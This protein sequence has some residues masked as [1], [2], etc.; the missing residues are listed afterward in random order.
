MFRIIKA[1]QV[2][3]GAGT[4]LGAQ[5]SYVSETAKP[6][7]IMR[8]ADRLVAAFGPEMQLAGETALEVEVHWA[9]DSPAPPKLKYARQAGA[10]T[11]TGELNAVA[12]GEGVMPADPLFAFDA[13][14]LSAAAAAALSWLE[15]MDNDAI[16]AAVRGMNEEFRG[17]VR[18]APARWVNVLRERAALGVPKHR[19]ELYR[20]QTPNRD[21]VA[22]P[23]DTALIEYESDGVRGS[24][25]LERIVMVRPSAEA[26]WRT[27]GYVFAPLPAP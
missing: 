22:A 25:V 11:R 1:G 5:V 27:G 13:L 2:I 20:M 21:H 7:E 6:Q 4:S 8:D 15:L 24:R 16:E 10:W 19:Q 23:S 12:L 9:H 14:K 17:Q 18:A 3:R 26:S